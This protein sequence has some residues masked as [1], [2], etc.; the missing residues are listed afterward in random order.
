[1]MSTPEVDMRDPRERAP[2]G[3]YRSNAAGR[4]LYV[5]PALAAMLGYDRVGDV[6]ALR[7]AEDVYADPADRPRLIAQC[8]SAAWSPA[9]RPGGGPGPARR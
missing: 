1:M 2:I 9:S 4:F 6:L 5:S 8:R 3:F 7:L